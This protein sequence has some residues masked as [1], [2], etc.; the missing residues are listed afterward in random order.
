MTFG[1]EAI[2]PDNST[3]NIAFSDL[4]DSSA[5]GFENVEIEA[6]P[7]QANVSDASVSI[8][9]AFVPTITFGFQF[10]Q[11]QIEATI[12]IFSH[13]PTLN[14]TFALL[15]DV[16]ANCEPLSNTTASNPEISDEEMAKLLASLGDLTKITSSVDLDVGI[17]AELNILNI[18]PV[19]DLPSSLTLFSTSY[20]I[21]TACLAFEPTGL[22]FVP[23]SEALASATNS[24]LSSLSAAATTSASPT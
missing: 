13:L 21:G 18:I 11:G 4:K 17:G 5:S 19:T 20:P 8:A 23:A 12:D 15:D 9:V 6:L 2:I 24:Y 16:D 22:S 10:F 7:F 3:I 1:V 14:S